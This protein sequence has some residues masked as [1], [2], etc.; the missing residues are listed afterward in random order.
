[1]KTQKKY[2]LGH[3]KP[4]KQDEFFIES[5][6]KKLWSA[7]SKD[8][9]DACW[10]TNMP[11][12]DQFKKLD[13]NK[14]INH[15]PGNSALTIK[16]SLYKTLNKAKLAVQGLPQERRYQFFPMTYS[17]PEEYFD[18]QQAAAQNPDSMWIQ[19]PR[20]MSRGRGIEMV[21]HP[22]TVPLSNEWIIQRYLDKPH[23]WDG[24]KYVLRCYVLV[25]S[26]EPLRFYWYHE[27]SAKL[28]SEK[29]DLTDLDNPY[30]HLTNPDINENNSDAEVPVTFHSFRVYKEWLRSQNIDV[31]KLFAGI[32]DLI[33]ISVIAAR[34][35]MREQSQSYG[36]DTQGAY[37]L[38]GLDCVIDSE[39]KPWILECNLS[40]SL[41]ICSTDEAQGKE[42][43]QTKKGMV[44]E[45][46]HMLGLNDIDQSTLSQSEKTHRELSRAKGFQCVFPTKD[47]NNYLHCF[48]VPRA[49]DVNSL[50]KDFAIDYTQLSLQSNSRT[51][52]V[53][54]DSLALLAHDPMNRTSAYITPNELASWIWLQNAD[55]KKPN[56]IAQEL[57]QMFGSATD[58]DSTQEQTTLWSSQVWDMLADWSQANLFNQSEGKNSTFTDTQST[59]L[60]WENTRYLNLAGVSVLIRCACPVAAQYI[61]AFTDENAASADNIKHVDIL[62]SNYGY[63]FINGPQVLSGSRKLSR[64]IDDCVKLISK[65]CL[66]EDDISL[67]QGAILSRNNNNA[68]VVGNDELLDSFTYEFCLDKGDAEILSGS[69]IL[70]V[71]N[72]VVKCTDLPILL[73]SNT[74]SISGTYDPSN[75]YPQKPAQ[76]NSTT[77]KVL[78]KRDW[79]ISET[80]S[81]PCWLAPAN[82][83]IEKFA[84]INVIIFIESSDEF[85]EAIIEP[86]NSADTLAQLWN[87]SINKKSTTAENLPQWLKG[88]QGYKLRCVD[89]K[90][91]KTMINSVSELLN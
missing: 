55:A 81:Q 48:P 7:G 8:D 46:V 82:G 32:E 88:I 29:F 85:P 36:V 67:V 27:G 77:N 75:Y 59:P 39:L 12:P 91:A 69:P 11:N 13:A 4:G 10:S 52:A 58:L 28:T 51:E 57:T 53:F 66:K 33:G 49:A 70:S 31:E 14:T 64:L 56:D 6:D 42:E 86:M 62:R 80:A 61:Q 84:Q 16:S 15:I 3:K 54:D 9:W 72:N 89:L 63:V 60:N 90:Q 65:S 79:L 30:R 21:Q 47:A 71:Q 25:T 17:M 83:M 35:K 45:I 23:L 68:I 34:E 40:P 43:I 44:A 73:P 78:V 76:V 37:E 87:K 1:M 2:W 20:N 18:F 19:K 41:D 5:L 38:L 26:I 74:D 22:E 50:P 24:F